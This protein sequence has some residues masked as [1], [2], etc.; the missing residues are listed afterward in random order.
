ML[1]RPARFAERMKGVGCTGAK[2]SAAGVTWHA[3]VRKQF[4]LAAQDVS[5][6]ALTRSGCAGSV[7]RR[8]NWLTP[9]DRSALRFLANGASFLNITAN[10][11][12]CLVL[13]AVVGE[14]GTAT[15]QPKFERMMWVAGTAARGRAQAAGAV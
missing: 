1:S 7:M 12:Q 13:C 11:P 2:L 4:R 8:A 9:E 3:S 14:C 6:V 10:F 5:G 15:L